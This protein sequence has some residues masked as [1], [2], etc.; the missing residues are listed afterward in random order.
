MGR[1]EEMR[2]RRRR[3]ARQRALV[4]AGA[5]AVTGA[6]LGVW[7][8]MR[9]APVRSVGATAAAAQQHAPTSPSTGHSSPT[10]T[11]ATSPTTTASS[12]GSASPGALVTSTA[13]S[14]Y[15]QEAAWVIA[16]NARP[17]SS[18]WQ[19]QGSPPGHIDGYADHTS[20]TNGETVA[21][22]VSTDAASY[23]IEAFRMGYYGGEGARLVW[24]SG[25]E[26]GS[27]QAQCVKAPIVNMVSCDTWTPSVQVAIG[28]DF[29]PG[30][31]LLKL[32]G[33][34]GQQSYVPLTITDPSSNAAYLVENDIYTWQAWNPFGGYDFYQGVGQCP[35]GVYPVCD[36]A[37]VVSFDRPYGYGQGAGDFLGNEYPLIR[38]MEQHGLD[39]SYATSADI[40]QEP[41]MLLQHRALL[42]L[43]HDECWSY[44]ERLSA[45]QAEQK[46]VNMIFFGA[47]AMLRHVR[48][49]PSP[50]GPMR[51]EVD[52]RD[53]GADPINGTGQPKQVTGNTWSDPPASWSQVPFVGEQYTGYVEPGY[54]PVDLVV[55]DGSSW[56]FAGTGLKSG[57]KVPGLLV[58]DFDQVEPGMS[59]DNVEVLAH[60]PMPRRE[61][62]SN[63]RNPASDAAY[64]TDARSG[65]GVFDSGTV[66][67][68]PDLQSSPAV[69]QMTGNLFKL[70]GEGPAGQTTPSVPNW[71]QIYLYG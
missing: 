10:A 49:E 30:D 54:K 4:A 20:A 63:V 53:S 22:Y 55:Y 8:V 70:F 47:S 14:G 13:G 44:S 29:V 35:S 62:Q 42:S 41:S 60:S 6:G 40:E 68:I 59:P 5:L 7:A 11:T 1:L 33:A 69:D 52:Y 65:A 21:L 45:E 31:Y 51:Q 2:R 28:P 25:A 23:R 37:R 57:D 50:L 18:D 48:L 61:V 16:E 67:W 64:W 3:R 27:E 24:S 34:G 9:P 19:I 36:R 46:G 38:F 58:S 15:G 12:S 43:G 32:V 26:I 56:L 71:R 17:G 66:T 39:V